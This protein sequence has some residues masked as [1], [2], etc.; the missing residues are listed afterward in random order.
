VSVRELMAAF[1]EEVARL[2]ENE[3]LAVVLCCLEGCAL[4]ESARRLGWPVGSV[5]GRLERGRARLRARLVR[6]GLSLPA[7]LATLEVTA[8]ELPAAFVSST[9]RGA[10]GGPA[11]EAVLSLAAGALRSAA[12]VRAKVGLVLLGLAGLTAGLAAVVGPRP[13]VP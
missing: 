5:K 1:D 7:A 11:P 2:P 9:L 3:R 12:L 6:R 13:T 10:V 8:A 4:E